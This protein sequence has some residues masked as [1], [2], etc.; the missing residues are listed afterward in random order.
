M[1]ELKRFEYIME[2][3][4]YYMENKS[5]EM[6]FKSKGMKPLMRCAD[7]RWFQCNMRQDGYLPHNVS[8]YECRHWC[9]PCDPTDYC[10]YG[11]PPK[12]E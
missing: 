7:C 6:C 5:G 9:G 11:E 12:E 8:E 10:S 3:E 2:F 1:A 4:P